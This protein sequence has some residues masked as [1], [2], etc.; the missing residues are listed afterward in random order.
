[1]V[2][3]NRGQPQPRREATGVWRQ[4]GAAGERRSPS[5]S[6]DVVHR[7]G[8]LRGSFGMARPGPDQQEE[9]VA[10]RPARTEP[11]LTRFGLRGL[12]VRGTLRAATTAAA[13]PGKSGWCQ[14]AASNAPAPVRGR[15]SAARFT[16]K[17][18]HQRRHRALDPLPAGVDCAALSRLSRLSTLVS[19]GVGRARL[20]R[21]GIVIGSD[22][23]ATTATRYARAPSDWLLFARDQ[24]WLA[25]SGFP[26]SMPE[27]ARGA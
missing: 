3:D 4:R 27:F 13:S 21:D 23:S 22:K 15:C 18:G 9:A 12:F 24:I 25:L 17:E 20:R 1:M 10:P 11:I 2:W 26:R 7:S 8:R 14:L 19:P 6:A 5:V 16:R